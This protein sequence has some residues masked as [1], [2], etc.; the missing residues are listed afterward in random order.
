M[1]PTRFYYPSPGFSIYWESGNGKQ[2]A[3]RLT[4]T[5]PEKEEIEQFIPRLFETDL[6]ADQVIREVYQKHGFKQAD[7]WINRL[8][9]GEEISGVPNSLKELVAE[10]TTKPTWLNEELLEQGAFMGFIFR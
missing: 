2:L 9:S 4:E 1:I 7:Q 8:L 6:L 5:L 3:K 10:I